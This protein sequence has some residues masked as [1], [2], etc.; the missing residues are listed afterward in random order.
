MNKVKTKVVAACIL[1]LAIFL[2]FYIKYNEQLEFSTLTQFEKIMQQKIKTDDILFVNDN[3]SLKDYDDLIDKIKESNNSVAILL[4]QIF[5]MKTQNYLDEVNLEYLKKIK[6]DYK[7]VILKVI[8]A[9]NILPVVYLTNDRQNSFTDGIESFGYFD[10]R[11][12]N[13]DLNK[14]DYHYVRA[15]NSKLFMAIQNM[16]FYKEDNHYP[17]K[18][19]IL[20]KYRGT[21]FVNPI[22]EAIRKYYRFPK[23]QI[24]FDRGELKISNIISLPLLNN[25]EIL[26][27]RLIKQPKVYSFKEFLA[28]GKEDTT[29][30]II[31]INDRENTMDTMLGLGMAGESILKQTYIRY[32][33]NL[34]FIIA[35]ISLLIFWLAYRNL[36][37]S[38]AIILAALIE[39]ITGIVVSRLLTDNFYLDFSVI[40]AVNVMAFFII[41]FYRISNELLLLKERKAVFSRFMRKDALEHFILKNRDIKIKD[42]WIR[43][44]AIYLFFDMNFLSSP[45]NIKKVFEKIEEIIYNKQQDILI[46][47][48]SSN[49]ISI[50]SFGESK[51]LTALID[52]LFEIKNSLV[53]FN[54][55][56]LLNDSEIYIFEYNRDIIFLDKN[57]YLKEGMET[58][59][60]KK[61]I[62]VP[63]KDIQ[64][65][66]N[67]TKF[68]KIAD[69]ESKNIF[70]NILGTR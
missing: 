13:L 45:Q 34:N 39:L 67:L 11:K 63:E 60:R 42:T 35:F 9:Q 64:N 6:E 7:E 62:I 14:Y 33:P 29:D 65:Y 8:E 38:F 22:I 44:F 41:Y 27:H 20:F 52:M 56:I 25:G 10:S 54:F 40:S 19:P 58:M 1:I 15:N 70:F 68:Q 2:F 30:K 46:K 24:K 26:I 51:D 43:A 47:I 59:E 4:P 17:Y 36:G 37:F 32:S 49:E 48:N 16:G 31:I 18:M 69:A 21:V 55:N 50:V 3:F 66:I 53:E 12:I 61:Y 5:C 57:Y 28:L 23:T